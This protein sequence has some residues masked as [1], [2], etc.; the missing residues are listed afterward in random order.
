[1]GNSAFCILPE[2]SILKPTQQSLEM[3]RVLI[4]E[5]PDIGVGAVTL[6]GIILEKV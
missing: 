6:P 5:G 4:G 3:K 2:V 1:M